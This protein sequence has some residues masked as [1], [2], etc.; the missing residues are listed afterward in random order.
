[1]RSSRSLPIYLWRAGP[2][3]WLPLGPRLSCWL[4]LCSPPQPA[5]PCP[6]AA[7][8]FA[9]GLRCAPF[10]CRCASAPADPAAA[11]KAKR[12]AEGS[13]LPLPT[14]YRQRHCHPTHPHNQSQKTTVAPFPSP[15]L[16]I[17]STKTL[18]RLFFCSHKN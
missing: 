16:P 5:Q 1:V 3:Y 11:L 15:L 7:F 10:F 4:L 8:A 12:S 9:C 17:G 6:A 14:L 13:S 2:F 18:L